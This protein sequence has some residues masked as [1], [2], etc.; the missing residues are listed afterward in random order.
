MT[1][2]WLVSALLGLVL[3]PL[4]AAEEPPTTVREGRWF[5]VVCHF[6]H[7][8]A[9]DDALAAVEAVGP[10]A[11]KLYGLRSEPAGDPLE[12][13]LY[14]T[15]ADYEAADRELTGGRFQR[16]LAFAHHE[17]R[18]AHVALQ[19]PVGE[20]V[21]DRVGL[22]VLTQKLLAHEAAHILRYR[23][24]PSFRSHP[25]WI[26]D[27]AAT[28]LAYRA[29]LARKRIESVE[30]SP[31]GATEIGRAKRVRKEG[32]LPSVGDLLLDR[33]DELAF[34]ERYACRWLLFRF[35][36][37]GARAEG[38]ATVLQ[39]LR[40]MGGGA[41][42]AERLRTRVVAATADTQKLDTGFGAWLDRLEP[43]WHE[44]FRS[45]QTGG[46]A[47]MQA[48]FPDT[49][50]IAWRTTPVGKEAYALGGWVEVL[51]GANVQMNVLLDKTDA[52]F[53][54]VALRA[55][56]WL[57]VFDYDAKTDRW[58][59]L[60]STRHEALRAKGR[61]PF[62]LR[63]GEGRLAVFLEGEEALAVD[64]SGRAMDGPWGLGA[65]AGT[66]GLWHDV[67]LT[68]ATAGARPSGPGR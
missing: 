42:F 34:Y 32:R 58:N 46:G 65:Q 62:L 44:R 31:L 21:L 36:A 5:R 52:G 6:R 35:L 17:S 50:A 13:H 64:V 15:T 22:P 29:L 38:F 11:A 26:V 7:D 57:T 27:G 45:L 63:V 54:S 16:N 30:Q 19:P 47:W 55:D 48:A 67:V 8:R 2:R 33:T 53:V 28:E 10:L 12:V 24:M 39:R 1:S 3:A 66:C 68:P 49:N 60:G 14:F 43:A 9:A 40:Q 56:G 37:S 4:V 20:E 25:M 51:P 18:S 61:V 59:R 23:A 41:D